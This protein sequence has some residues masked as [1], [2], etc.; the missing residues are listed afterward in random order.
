MLSGRFAQMAFT[1]K[2]T[3]AANRSGFLQVLS[4][5]PAQSHLNTPKSPREPFCGSPRVWGN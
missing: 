2:L 5:Q 4:P 3:Q 1:P